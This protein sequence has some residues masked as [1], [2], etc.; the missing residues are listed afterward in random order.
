MGK[1]RRGK[2]S[3]FDPSPSPLALIQQQDPFQHRPEPEPEIIHRGWFHI[4]AFFRIF[5]SGRVAR[6]PDFVI[7]APCERPPHVPLEHRDH[8]ES[9]YDHRVELARHRHAASDLSSGW[10]IFWIV[11]CAVVAIV[12]I[13]VFGNSSYK[14]WKDVVVIIVISLLLLTYSKYVSL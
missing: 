14:H 5:P 13:I 3:H 2:R 9:Y 1:K 10:C 8:S 4:I 6:E 11:I 7:V 12:I